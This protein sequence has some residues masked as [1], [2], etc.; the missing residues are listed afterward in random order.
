MTVKRDV[1]VVVAVVFT[2]LRTGVTV[3]REV[4]RNGRREAMCAIRDMV[5]SATGRGRRVRRL[6][7]KAGYELG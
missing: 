6:R 2:D 4:E 7:K 3:I 5:G 1:D